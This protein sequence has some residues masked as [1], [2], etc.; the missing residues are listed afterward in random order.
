[1][2]TEQIVHGPY[3]PDTGEV[4]PAIR[5]PEGEGES[6]PFISIVLP[7]WREEKYIENC[8]N[9]ILSQNYPLYRMEILVVDGMST[10]RTR[11]IVTQFSKRYPQ[12]RLLDNPQRLQAP[13]LN[14]GILSSRGMYII[15]MDA[16]SE[17]ARDYLRNCVMT[18][19]K[20]K[21]DNVGG[22]A[23]TKAKSFFQRMVSHALNSRLGTGG[24]SFRHG[25]KDGYV[26]TVFPGAF[27]RQAL[28]RVGLFDPGAITNEDA[29]INQRILASGG[30]IYL[31]SD[32]EC[33]YYPRDSVKSLAVQ[34]FKY[35]RGRARTVLKHRQIL[36]IS[37]FLPFL[38]VFGL[39]ALF[40]IGAFFEP[41]LW[42]A[43]GASALYVGALIGE[44]IRMAAK[45]EWR[46]ALVL[47]LVFMISHVFH[48]LGVGWGLLYYSYNPDW[49][50][51]APPLLQP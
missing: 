17:Y 26:D 45:N 39:M 40:A 11:E 9:C 49:L 12:V 20:T 48:A 8:L 46:C 36:R 10:D 23:R 35:G 32:I 34:Y 41:A 7:T 51:Q 22:P 18:L 30:K 2:L 1:M 15:R 14:K 50:K 16:H 37:S 33:Y 24:A 19:Q 47:P 4:I 25:G 42:L 6:L 29:E 31:S 5:I 27:R 43:L 28:Q 13:G 3:R 21:A 44:S 38:F